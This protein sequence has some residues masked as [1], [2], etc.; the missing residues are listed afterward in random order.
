[1][2]R[3][4]SGRR[5][6]VTGVGVVSPLGTGF[7]THW[8]RLLAGESGVRAV[9]GEIAVALPGAVRAPVTTLDPT[10]IR[11]RMLRKLLLP[12]ATFAVI[13]AGDALADAGLAGDDACLE[14]CGIYFGS[15]AYE[16]PR[17][18]FHAALRASFDAD[19]V[20]DFERFGRFGIEQIDP[21]LIVKGLPNAAPC[22]VA[23]EHGIRGINASFTSGATA[24]LQAAAAAWTAIRDGLVDVA[25]VGGS[26]SLLLADHFVAHHAAG[27]L[28]L[29]GP[30]AS[31]A[32]RPFDSAPDGYALGEGAAC[33]VLEAESHARARAVRIYAEVRGASETTAPGPDPSGDSLVAAVRAAL[34]DA[35][36]PDAA[37]VSGVGVAEDDRREWLACTRLWRGGRPMTA[38]TGAIGLTG[39]ASGAF[40]LVH[41]VRAIADGVVP[42]TA[43]CAQIDP[44]CE[45]PIVRRAERRRL[46]GVAVWAT[47]NVRNAAIMLGTAS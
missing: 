4:P 32:A 25:I 14:G 35:A 40:A 24:G 29:T 42:P 33:C 27:R 46:A 45:A 12:S 30:A 5:V 44:A 39:A 18:T 10:R 1:V 15:V 36:S 19:G 41:A 22:G 34:P 16:V 37:F 23:I 13:A 38:A 28:A 47:D 43:G 11:N 21:L 9:E 3:L 7:A 31:S 17:P 20:F 2:S 8:P 26:D 6:V